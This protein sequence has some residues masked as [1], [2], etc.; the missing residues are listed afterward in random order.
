MD[1]PGERPARTAGGRPDGQIAS[2]TMTCSAWMN[3]NAQRADN[4]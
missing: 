3:R 4:G 1:D 2:R